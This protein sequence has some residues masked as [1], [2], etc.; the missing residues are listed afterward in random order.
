MD[1]MRQKQPSQIF[2]DLPDKRKQVFRLMCE[3]KTD[4]EI[5]DVMGITPSTVRKQIENLGNDFNIGTDK[6]H[7]DERHSRREGLLEIAQQ[8]GLVPSAFYIER[9]PIETI[10]YQEILKPGSLLRIRASKQMGKTLL[11]TQIFEEAKKQG[12]KTAN[13]NLLQLQEDEIT[14]IDKLLRSLCIAVTRSLNLNHSLADLWDETIGSKDNCTYYLEDYILSNLEFPLVLGLDNVDRVFHLETISTDLFGLLR[15]W[16]ETAKTNELWQQVRFVIAYST[17]NYPKLSINNS[18]FN[19]GKSIELRGFNTEQ[20]QDLSRRY[21]IAVD[22]NTVSRLMD[23]VDGHPYLVRQIFEQIEANPD[24][25]IAELLET[26][27]TNAGIYT[28]YLRDISD[29]LKQ[30]VELAVAFKIVL[31]AEKPVR[32]DDQLAFKLDSLGLVAK[33]GNHVTP[34][35][36]LYRLYFKERL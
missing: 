3:G 24:L 8:L 19:V 14:N 10:C 11:M 31:D 29:T 2:N 4:P 32:I 21:G 13:W 7:S 23:M 33:E 25:T 35:C 5:A 15:F 34:R 28:N 12:Y 18:P 1:T 16:Y 36:N 26:A 27:A 30:S 9:P 22:S 20:V 6:N 17:S